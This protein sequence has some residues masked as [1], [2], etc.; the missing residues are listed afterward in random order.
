MYDL[1]LRE[2]QLND[3]ESFLLA[4]D[5][6]QSL[7]GP[8]MSAPLTH[9]EFVE[10]YNRYNQS[11][12]KSFLL[13]NKSNE[14]IGVFNLSEIVRGIFQNAY[15]GFSA[16]IDFAGKGYM[17]R[18]LKLILDKVFMEMDLH[19]LEA[20]IQPENIRSLNLVKNNG[21]SKEGFSKRYLKINGEWRDFE[22]WAITY[23]DWQALKNKNHV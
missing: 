7:Y 19:R 4:M 22:R 17:S 21:F 9:D 18:G 2:L 5:K 11:N 16:V 6:S 1:H 23:E 15:L 20:N 8:W 13:S 3:E 12:H 14:I 10:F